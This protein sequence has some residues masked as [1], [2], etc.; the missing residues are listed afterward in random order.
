VTNLYGKPAVFGTIRDTFSATN[1]TTRS[2][3]VISNK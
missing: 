1:F 3:K 2:E